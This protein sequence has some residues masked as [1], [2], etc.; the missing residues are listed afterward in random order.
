MQASSTHCELVL[1]FL[2]VAK[3][4]LPSREESVTVSSFAPATF[5]IEHMCTHIFSLYSFVIFYRC[6]LTL[7]YQ[8]QE[9]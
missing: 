6:L 2:T 9:V 1:P 3:G 7:Q 8:S 5:F 4:I